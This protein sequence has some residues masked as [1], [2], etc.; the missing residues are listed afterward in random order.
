MPLGLSDREL[1]LQVTTRQ[2][3]DELVPWEVEAEMNRGELP[4]EVA[5]AHAE[6]A[7]GLGLISINMPE[8]MGG[9]GYSMMEQVLIQEQTGRVTNALGWVVSTGPSW[10][11]EVVTEHQMKT[12]IAP[13]VAGE[14]HECYAITEAGAGSDVDA[15]RATAR[16][17]GDAYVLDGE[18]W[19]V[20]SANLASYVFFQAKLTDGPNAGRHVLF[21]VDMDTPGV[22]CVR[23]PEYSHTYAHHHWEMRLNEV[24]VPAENLVGSE[25]DG[26]GFSHAW[27]RYERLMIAARCCGA[28]GRLIEEATAFAAE[29]EAYGE[30]I[31]DYQAIQFMLA[32]SLTELW[33]A[34]LMTYETARSIDAGEDLKVQ[35]AR[36]SM[37]K[38]YASEMANRVADRA[39]QIFG[40]R[41][42]MREN[43]AE[44]FY[45]ELRVDRIWEGTSEIQRI[46]IADQ[47]RKR[48][49]AP[50]IG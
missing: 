8:S 33:A 17:E 43:V 24:K 21:F 6:K 4:P 14:I 7:A 49:P 22:E 11:E 37:A 34:R 18:K 25:G 15:I 32:D 30:K 48:G 44:R 20:T 29:R 9:P 5:T 23:V 1:A 27:F 28:A 19:H 31:I 46:I 40:G 26:M 45:R 2:F 10:I 41:G 36:C 13:T 35:H 38:L 12:W 3:V 50:L 42:F 39:V 16:R 47:L